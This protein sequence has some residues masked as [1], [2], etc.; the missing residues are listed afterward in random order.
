MYE[1]KMKFIILSFL[2]LFTPTAYCAGELVDYVKLN[3]ISSI[4]IK[5]NKKLKL[6]DVIKEP[7]GTKQVLA[8]VIYLNQDFLAQRDCLIFDIPLKKEPGSLYVTKLK[9]DELCRFELYSKANYKL[10]GIYNMGLNLSKKRFQITIDTKIININLLNKDQGSR[11]QLGDHS[12]SRDRISG[13]K[14]SLAPS[15]GAISPL[16]DGTICYEVDDNCKVIKDLNCNL[17][18]NGTYLVKASQCGTK[19]RQVCGSSKCGT[20]GSPACMRGV[21]A[22]GYTGNYCI[23]DS[24][25]GLCYKG[26]RVFCENG[27]LICN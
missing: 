24:P 27:A 16:N 8:E 7:A 3:W 1:T 25:I 4:E 12:G 13:L 11:F 5:L 15:N 2:A 14:V 10:N 21:V 23:P 19:L 22:S 20:K 9:G 17:C 26:L 6:N 18:R